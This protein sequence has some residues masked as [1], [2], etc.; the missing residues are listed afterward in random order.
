MVSDYNNN[1][2]STPIFNLLYKFS[3]YSG[4]LS[5]NEEYGLVDF[6]KTSYKSSTKQEST[7]LNIYPVPSY[8]CFHIVSCPF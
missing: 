2:V 7:I 3:E 8:F 1:T 4:E 6:K 5:G